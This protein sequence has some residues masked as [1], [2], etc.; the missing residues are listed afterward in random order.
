MNLYFN[1]MTLQTGDGIQIYN[2]TQSINEEVIKS[3]IKD[4]IVNIMSRH[5]TT[6]LI[7]NEYEPR[8]LEDLRLFFKEIAP[9]SRPYQHNDIHLRDCPPN[10]PK[11]AHSHILAM[12]LSSHETVP[13]VNGSLSLGRWQSVLLFELD[14]PR[15]RQVSVQIMGQ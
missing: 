5:T 11:N 12:L 1:E 3:R 8:L 15:Q 2:I 13:L 10:E 14:G 6:A 9:P 7:I 4:G